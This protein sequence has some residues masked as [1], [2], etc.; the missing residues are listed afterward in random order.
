MWSNVFDPIMLAHVTLTGQLAMMMLLEGV[1]LNNG[2]VLS[3]NTDGITVRVLKRYRPAMDAMVSEWCEKT[4][5]MMDYE[6]YRSIHYQSISSYF[7]HHKAGYMSGIGFFAGDGIRKSPDMS[8]IRDSLFA[9]VKDGVDVCESVTG[10]KELEPYTILAGISGGGTQYGEPIGKLVRFYKS[11][12]GETIYR[13]TP[14]KSGSY[15]KVSN[16]DGAMICNDIPSEL[17]ADIDYEYYIYECYRQMVKLSLISE[18]NLYARFNKDAPVFMI[19]NKNDIQHDFEEISF[20]EFLVSIGIDKSWCTRNKVPE[21]KRYI[22]VKK[23]T[24]RKITK[25]VKK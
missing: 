13:A 25:E 17:P 24:P 4:G 3:A 21:L 8:I 1:Y 15:N 6:E 22:P 12:E 19:V 18:S 5:F 20:S 9:Y 11:T 14:T 23:R 16:S 7:Y 10:C 2:E